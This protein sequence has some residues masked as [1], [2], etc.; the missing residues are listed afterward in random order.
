[1][2]IWGVME[3]TFAFYGSGKMTHVIMLLNIVKKKL[4][5][6]SVRSVL[7]DLLSIK[8]KVA[9]R[10]NHWCIMILQLKH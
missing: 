10:N 2:V 1:M 9:W 3:I 4:T 7:R 5:N 6:E 8:A